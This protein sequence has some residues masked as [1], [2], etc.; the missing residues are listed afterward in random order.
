MVRVLRVFAV[1]VPRQIVQGLIS[2]GATASLV[3]ENREVTVL[4]T[5]ISGCRLA[6]RI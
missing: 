5:D 1:Y 3:S 4:F 6:P 2:R